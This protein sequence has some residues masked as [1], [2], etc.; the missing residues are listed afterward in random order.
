ML[1]DNSIDLRN[2]RLKPSLVITTKNRKDDLRVALNSTF[3]QSIDLEVIVIDDGSTDGTSTM[4]IEEFPTAI[5]HRKDISNG[6]IAAR[7][8][9]AELA[10]GDVIFSIDDDAAFSDPSIVS[11]TLADFSDPR[12]GAVAIPFI[13]VNKCPDIRQMAPERDEIWVT[14]SF[15]GTA[16]AIRRDVFL[17]MGGYRE[18]LVHQGEE[19][20]LCIRMLDAGWVV[21]QGS[22]EPIHHYESPRRDFRRMDLHGRRNDVLFAWH[23][24]PLLWL[25]FHLMAT[26]INGIVF[27]IRVGR[28]WRM[29]HGLLLGYGACFKFWRMRKPVSCRT[30]NLC[31]LLKKKGPFKFQDIQSQ[32]TNGPH[33]VIAKKSRE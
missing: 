1:T 6:Y 29:M 18:H 31:R 13:D 9:G 15:I 23:N 33:H 12:I 11:I 5:I 20:D 24:V 30:Y 10:S 17:S 27:G 4:V 8:L 16:H 2:N 28:P 25:P 7:N 3:S 32:L 26:T 14:E 22:S 19:G 21:R